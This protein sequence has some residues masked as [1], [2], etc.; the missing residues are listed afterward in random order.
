MSA[1]NSPPS[2]DQKHH[3]HDTFSYRG[4]LVS[5]RR[6]RRAIAAAFYTLVVPTVLLLVFFI[7]MHVI[8]AAYFVWKAVV[9]ACGS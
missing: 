5:D 2:P 7:L 4:W 9:H 3:V 8:L 1:P 6:H